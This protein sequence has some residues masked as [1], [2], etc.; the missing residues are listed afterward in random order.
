M[1]DKFIYKL[2]ASD[3]VIA[4]SDIHIVVTNKQVDFKTKEAV[5]SVLEPKIK[6][7]TRDNG[8]LIIDIDNIPFDIITEIKIADDKNRLNS[9][10]CE[11]DCFGLNQNSEKEQITV[12]TLYADEFEKNIFTD[13][14]GTQ[15]TYW[16][17]TPKESVATPKPLIIWEHTGGEV[18]SLSFE[19]ANLVANQGATTWLEHQYDALVLS[20]QYPENYS[21]GISDIP[22]EL[23]LME[24]YNDAKYELI[25]TLINDGKVD[26]NRILITGASS[27]GGGAIRFLMQYPDLFAGALIVS[28]KDTVVPIS[29]KYNLAYQI[30]DN[31]KLKLT[32][33][34]YQETYNK[35]QKTLSKY[36]S[37]IKVPIWFVQAENDQI[38]TYYTVEMMEKILR[39]MGAKNNKITIYSDEAMEA[40]GLKKVYHGAW[41]IVYQNKEMLDWLVSKNIEI[42]E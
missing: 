23:S 36:G 12:S 10:W 2:D 40:A 8:E 18:L 5:I 33:E 15:I 4:A 7:I 38:T 14:K 17:Y 39:G 32:Q 3:E 11:R 9:I 22:E 29:K 30:E 21:F 13:S 20:I 16:L 26:A 41:E 37:L 6:S 1:L 25:Q 19:R 35:M 24:A 31:A 42:T 34:Q 27:G 28:A